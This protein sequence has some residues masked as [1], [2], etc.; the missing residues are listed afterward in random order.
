[1]MLTRATYAI[2]WGVIF[3]GP[4]SSQVQSYVPLAIPEKSGAVSVEAAG[5]AQHGR[6]RL[7][8]NLFLQS[9]RH[10]SGNV[11]KGFLKARDTVA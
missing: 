6:V 3:R 1:M 11:S 5:V 2:K 4:R 9:H 7:F 8:E 10:L